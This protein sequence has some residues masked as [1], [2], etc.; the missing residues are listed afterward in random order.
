MRSAVIVPV[1]LVLG[2]LLAVPAAAQAEPAGT[3]LLGQYYNNPDAKQLVASRLDPNIAFDWGDRRPE[4]I[5]LSGKGDDF[6]AVWTGFVQPEFSERY[7]FTT[8]SDDGVRLTIDGQVVLENF[9]Q[10]AQA[11]DSGSVRL[12]AGRLHELKLEYFDSGGKALVFLAW[13][14]PSQ[15]RQLVPTERLYPPDTPVTGPAAT[16][17]PTA[18]PP[19]PPGPP[20]LAVT[21]TGVSGATTAGSPLLFTATV[22]NQ[23]ESPTPGGVPITV[24]FLAGPGQ[25]AAAEHPG[26]LAPGE[27]VNLTSAQPW[28]ARQ[29]EFA[30]SAQVD[31]VDRIAEADEDDNA[32]P[33]TLR[34]APAP[35][36]PV[37]ATAPETGGAVRMA[38][39]A[40]LALAVLL[41]L[42]NLVVVWRQRTPAGADGY[43]DADPGTTRTRILPA[44]DEL[45]GDNLFST[46]G[47]KRSR[48][49]TS[50]S[51]DQGQAP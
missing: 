36:V 31:E 43:A 45:E 14:S 25:L 10:H 23:G 42:V 1:V 46:V 44:Q 39:L 49:V 28:T 26:P 17:A 2:V 18:A 15:P 12:E 51:P 38:I 24:Q 9:T 20:D 3:G 47:T 27:V 29:G 30:V 34:I 41:L 16:P 11:Q 13:E 37:A 21:S 4:G 6:A 50:G 48:R 5:P 33:Q 8:S 40:L 32:A 22:V 35:V 19:P 7:T